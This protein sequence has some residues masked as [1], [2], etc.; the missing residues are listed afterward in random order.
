MS[1][2]AVRMEHLEWFI[3]PGAMHVFNVEAGV[4]H[5]T[6]AEKLEALAKGVGRVTI[7]SLDKGRPPR[8]WWDIPRE[9]SRSKERAYGYHPSMKPL[10]LCDRIVGIHSNLGSI[11]L[12]PFGGSGSE[13]VSA[14]LAGR[15]VIAFEKEEQY[16]QLIL[17]RM[18][19]W[20][21]LP[22][23]PSAK[24]PR[25]PETPGPDEGQCQPP[26]CPGHFML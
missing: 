16:Y 10:K 17:R 7:E 1:K 21:V 18:C 19:G 8:N 14:A 11:V 12:V 13:C 9:N 24:R 2:Y 26:R 3:K 25:S 23:L 15:R 5:Y 6:D 22:S 4:E 20:N